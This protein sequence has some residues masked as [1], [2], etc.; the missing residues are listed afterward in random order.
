MLQVK[1]NMIQ[2]DDDGV[3]L[4]WVD[5][6]F[7]AAGEEA[8]QSRHDLGRPAAEEFAEAVL[9]VPVAFVFVLEDG[10]GTVGFV[11]SAYTNG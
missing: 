6:I 8:V 9:A 3:I 1:L 4:Y 7:V 11:D 5:L 10:G 2:I